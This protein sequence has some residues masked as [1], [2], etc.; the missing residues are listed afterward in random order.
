MV[1]RIPHIGFFLDFQ[2][3]IDQDH[4]KIDNIDNTRQ[5]L[6]KL[7]LQIQLDQKSVIQMSDSVNQIYRFVII[8]IILIFKVISIF[9]VVFPDV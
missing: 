4:A 5:K 8:I 9:F 3:G 1:G 6:V 2:E 7:A